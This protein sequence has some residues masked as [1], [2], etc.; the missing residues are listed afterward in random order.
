[1]YGIYYGKKNIRASDVEDS[2]YREFNRVC[3]ACP[4]E[5]VAHYFFLYGSLTFKI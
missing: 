3:S 4:D 1:M 5:I 2:R